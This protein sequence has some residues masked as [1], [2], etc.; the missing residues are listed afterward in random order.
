MSS[1]ITC[2]MFIVY[3]KCSPVVM[4]LDSHVGYGSDKG[5]TAPQ[6]TAGLPLQTR[7][8]QIQPPTLEQSYDSI[9]HQRRH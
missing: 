5:Y 3:Y 4:E 6:G 7:D 1:V 2:P 9:S 8:L